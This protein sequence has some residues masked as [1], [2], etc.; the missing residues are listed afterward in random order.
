MPL[1]A[2]SRVWAVLI[3]LVI[4]FG[5]P[6]PGSAS[7]HS[8]DLFRQ[9]VK[10]LRALNY[11]AALENFAAAGRIEPDNAGTLLFIGMTLNR[12][13]RHAQAFSS[14]RLADLDDIPLPRIDFEIGWAAIGISAWEI[15]VDR[16]QRYETA[17]PGDAKTA[18]FL[19]RAYL[20]LGKL[21]LAEEYL[22]KAMR[23]DPEVKPTALYVLAL[24]DQAR[25]NATA[26][27]RRLVTLLEDVPDS[28][29]ARVLLDEHESLRDVHE[30][31]LARRRSM[32]KPWRFSATAATGYDSNV[33]ALGEGI[34]DP[35]DISDEGSMFVHFDFEASYDY[36]LREFQFLTAGYAFQSEFFAEDVEYDEIIQYF[37]LRY[38]NQLGPGLVGALQLSDEYTVTDGEGFRN[39]IAAKAFASYQLTDLVNAEIGFELSGT[40]Y[41]VSVFSP[42]L[43]RD[44]F[45]Q[46]LDVA[47][48]FALPIIDARGRVAY[49]FTHEDTDGADFDLVAHSLL[50]GLSR[51][52]WRDVT[53]IIQYTRTFDRYLNNNFFAGFAFDRSDDVDNLIVRLVWP[54]LG[55]VSIFGQYDYTH[56]DSNIAFYRYNRHA[57]SVGVTKNF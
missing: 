47:L 11:E 18:E 53:G 8:D 34:P 29:I 6:G 15:A 21:V 24:V 31:I 56:H 16:L 32:A 19:G 23:L 36:R 2:V 28:R 35:V 38:R 55:S 37:Y 10:E 26:A 44:S 7:N 39:R 48:N 14:L 57:I 49:I 30:R 54:V 43:D 5:F 3:A 51:T 41:F 27:G 22:R 17:R 1:A 40:D 13:G 33:I 4:A 20:G 25:G 42:L 45:G 52:V 9:G 46:R 50:A 12:L